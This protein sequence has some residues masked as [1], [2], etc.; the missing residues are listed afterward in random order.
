MLLARLLEKAMIFKN[1][2]NHLNLSK[3]E[4]TKI[5]NTHNN[6]VKVLNRD[7]SSDSIE[8]SFFT[9]KDDLN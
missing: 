8:Q 6:N 1:Q 3:Q 4:E 5:L 9:A 7:V 2:N